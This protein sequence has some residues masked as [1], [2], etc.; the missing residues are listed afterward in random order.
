MRP[1]AV[2]VLAPELLYQLSYRSA[3]IFPRADNRHAA[4]AGREDP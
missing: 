4:I 1:A 3:L 2:V